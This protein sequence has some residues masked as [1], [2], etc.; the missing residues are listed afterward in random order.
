MRYMQH[1]TAAKERSETSACSNCVCECVCVCAHASDSNVKWSLNLSLSW[2]SKGSR[3]VE[4]EREKEEKSS[5]CVCVR[6]SRGTFFPPT[7]PG[8]AGWLSGTFTRWF[9]LKD[10]EVAPIPF[11]YPFARYAFFIPLTFLSGL[12]IPIQRKRCLYRLLLCII[13]R[14]SNRPTA[15]RLSI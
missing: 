6:L 13:Y 14:A 2:S 1:T 5:R 8:S 11:S 12:L 3:K 15:K 10:S 9:T 7:V 4:R